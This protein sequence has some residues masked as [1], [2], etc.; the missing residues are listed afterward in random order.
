MRHQEAIS[1]V[2]AFFSLQAK[3]FDESDKTSQISPFIQSQKYLIIAFKIA[4]LRYLI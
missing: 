1:G 4:R 3:R 2:C